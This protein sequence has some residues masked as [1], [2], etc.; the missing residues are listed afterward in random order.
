MDLAGSERFKRV[1]NNK[2]NLH[3]QNFIN[4]SLTCLG[5]CLRS[6]QQKKV[7]SFRDNKL[8]YYLSNYF[9]QNNNITMIVN[10]NPRVDDYKE[11]LRVLN[12]AA[13]A[14]K[15][16]LFGNRV[17][18]KNQ[19]YDII[20]KKRESISYA[21]KNHRYNKKRFSVSINNSKLR[22]H[23]SRRENSV[24]IKNENKFEWLLEQ[25]KMFMNKKFDEQQK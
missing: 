10:I 12:Y 8:T 1:L 19:A 21:Q 4:N 15:V 7:P 2:E 9:T 18:N 13:I 17:D 11:S 5:R 25:L 3:E 16:E 14:K 6:L 22:N 24:Q 20:R 23:E